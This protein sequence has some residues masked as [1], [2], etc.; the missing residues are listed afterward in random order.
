[1]QFQ[2]TS[3]GKTESYRLVKTGT[4]KYGKTGEKPERLD[5]Y[6]VFCGSKKVRTFSGRNAVQDF[7]KIAT[8]LEAK[9]DSFTWIQ[10]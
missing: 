4:R 9:A 3:K 2:I 7:Q 8:Q 6:T 1:M 10:K 5:V